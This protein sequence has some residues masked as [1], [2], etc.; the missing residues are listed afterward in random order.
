MAII[1]QFDKRS[2]ITYVYDSE[3]AKIFSLLTHAD[4]LFSD[5]TISNINGK[6]K[7]LIVCTDKEQVLYQHLEHNRSC[8]IEMFTML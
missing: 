4:S 8:K 5:A 2:G 7:T 1:K 6:H 3:R